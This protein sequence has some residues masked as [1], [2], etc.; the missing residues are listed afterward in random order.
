M[1][2]GA[3]KRKLL[4]LGGLGALLGLAGPRR[5]EAGN[6]D[7]ILLG[8]QNNT[9]HT[10]TFLSGGPVTEPVLDISA[11]GNPGVDALWAVGAVGLLSLPGGTGLAAVGGNADSQGGIGA[12][13]VGGGATAGIGGV[14]AF[15]RGGI[16][17]SG[18]G[19][20]GCEAYGGTGERSGGDAVAA[21]ARTSGDD[22]SPSTPRPAGVEAFGGPGLI[23]KDGAPGIVAGGGTENS[24][25]T[26]PA[27]HGSGAAGYGGKGA[28]GRL[29]VGVLGESGPGG[30]GDA[31]VYG[32]ASALFSAGAYGS[33][34]EVGAY[35]QSEAGTAVGV[36]GINLGTGPGAFFTSENGPGIVARSING[37]GLGPLSSVDGA[38]IAESESG[39]G[40]VGSS[41]T[42]VGAHGFSSAASGGYFQTNVAS[43]SVPTLVASNAQATP[44]GGAIGLLVD[45][46]C[47]VQNGTKPAAL[48]TS[49]GLTL[50]YVVEAAT[51][52]FEDIGKAQL[53]NGRVR[54]ELDPLFAETIETRDYQ[55]F[56]TAR[57]DNRGLFVAVHDERGFEIREQAGGSSSIDVSYRVVGRR[58]GL[59][60][61][62]RLARFEPPTPPKPRELR[63]PKPP[64]L[65][66][67]NLRERSNERKVLK[68]AGD[69]M[70]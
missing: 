50:L 35:G 22:L 3:L 31:G 23:V 69:E 58:K 54:V 63:R 12:F 7:P 57:G 62:H 39:H 25:N 53:R 43:G 48:P 65:H 44:A 40:A 10:T 13:A 66:R 36:R 64:K 60:P 16:S 52:V 32:E 51:S 1:R 47:I 28:D 21:I 34:D 9:G 8:F 18:P 46:D 26:L 19:G 6:G 5:A 30:K 56:L 20:D 27:G 59:H 4:W 49:K 41:T 67:P 24:P 61:G 68:G 70:G 11:V 55:V 38:I 15:A 17:Q 45:G 42:G 2:T 29:A 14:G 37:R 33:G